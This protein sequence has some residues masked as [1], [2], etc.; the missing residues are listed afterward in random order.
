VTPPAAVKG[1]PD[2]LDAQGNLIE[3]E[4][5][6]K[7]QLRDR[8]STRVGV[9]PYR[10]LL[11]FLAICLG[12]LA[13]F[14]Y[15]FAA[16][17]WLGTF[18]AALLFS[19]AAL[20]AGGFFGFLFGLPHAG[21][22][23][24]QHQSGS[25]LAPAAAGAG[26]AGATAPGASPGSD[27]TA[28]TNLQQVADWLTKLILG[29]G[30]TQLGHLPHASSELF[31]SMSGAIGSTASSVSIAGGITIYFT[32]VGF[33]TGWLATYFFLTPAMNRVERN[34]SSILQQAK[35]LDAKADQAALAGQTARATTLRA[36]SAVQSD[37]AQAL[38][39]SYAN[40]YA[41]PTTDPSRVPDL[42]ATITRA[43]TEE[44][45]ANPSAGDVKAKY[46]A[47]PQRQKEVALAMMADRPSIAS[48]DALITSITDSMTS[49]EQYQA[50]RAAAALVPQLNTAEAAQLRT[51]VEAEM[52]SGEHFGKTSSRYI[53]AG[54]IVATLPQSPT[55]P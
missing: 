17:P 16:R 50:L 24:S 10:W 34:I 33:V 35:L 54:R 14:L 11:V 55:V 15:A 5:V 41:R 45:Q 12:V 9:I 53:L 30:L 22:G 20:G 21:A 29:A 44:L 6:D 46:D 13:E 52:N 18:S 19:L 38:L 49:V 3:N 48:L 43:S 36:A 4:P 47:G 26:A 51:A 40:V 39:Q 25:P 28:S 7:P 32:A 23:A 42:D 37:R 27:V 1:E 31:H 2:R 8:L